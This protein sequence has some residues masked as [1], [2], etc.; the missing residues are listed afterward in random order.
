MIEPTPPTPME[1]L[2]V[3]AAVILRDG[4]Y[5][6]ARRPA[7]K[8]HGGLWEFPGGKVDPGESWLDAA[9]RE[10]AEELGM[11]V[12][13]VGRT[14]RSI[15]DEGSPFVIHFV[16]VEADG[17]PVPTE[18][19]AV[20]WHTPSELAALPLAPAD[21]R[22]SAGLA[23]ADFDARAATWDDDP[24]RRERAAAVA[25]RI[26]ERIDLPDG[27]HLLDFGSGTGL[28]GFHFLG[29]A[30][31]VTFADPS[32]G[33]LAQ[34]ASKLRAAGHGGGRTLRLDPGGSSLPGNYGAIVSLMTLHHVPRPEATLALLA[35]HLEP[36]G[37]LALCDLDREDGTFHDDPDAQVHHGFE[38]G[39]L[40][41]RAEEL[42]L[43]RVATST[44]WVMRKEGPGGTR[45][46]PLFLFTARRPAGS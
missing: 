36:G 7:A 13:S 3:V 42:G 41:A 32:E 31:S 30:A 33:M 2:P 28:L 15:H 21:A 46:Y 19:E 44:A 25:A 14:L 37:W 6:V 26:M 4:R 11:D 5:L 40:V 18:H 45:E 17:E 16:E 1:P 23:Q 34:V 20:A 39:W 22:F 8:R 9:R 29:H 27:C 12:T 24:V 35:E 38:R 43:E 10:L